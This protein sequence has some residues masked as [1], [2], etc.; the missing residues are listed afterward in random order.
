[1]PD[2]TGNISDW[3]YAI[4]VDTAFG[5]ACS[6]PFE[7]VFAL[8]SCILCSGTVPRRNRRNSHRASR[9]VSANIYVDPYPFLIH[10]LSPPG[11][12][13]IAVYRL[14]P[15]QPKMPTGALC[16]RLALQCMRLRLGW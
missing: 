1:M 3:P 13:G 9:S 7:S 16:I 15:M 11:F 14:F 6:L 12:V 2:T 4:S 10:Q 8:F 5:N